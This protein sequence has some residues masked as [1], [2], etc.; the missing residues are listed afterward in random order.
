MRALLLAFIAT[1]I[2]MPASADCTGRTF[3]KTTVLNPPL[4]LPEQPKRIIALVPAFPLGVTIELGM[5]VVGSPLVGMNDVVMRDK[6]IAAGVTDLGSF[7]EPSIEKIIALKPD[8]IIGSDFLGEE[9]YQRASRIAPTAFVTAKNWKDHYRTIAEIGG[10]SDG[11][12]TLFADY[13]RRLAVLRERVPKDI[14]VS[15]VR[16]MS[17]EFQVYLDKPDTWAPFDILREAGVKRTAFETSETDEPTKRL[18]FEGLSALD[19]DI[20]LY[21][22]GDLNDAA[23]SGRHEAVIANPL[24]QMLPAVK[25]KRVYRVDQATWM[26]FNGIASAHKVLDDIETY[27]IGK[28]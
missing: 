18:D 23:I 22:I 2:S 17:N 15:V 10:R 3:D 27:I 20:L 5:P 1:T 8:L 28:P 11:L 26:E 12:E 25:A 14:K 13:D 6:V 7:L 19:G 16:I 4:C 24:W 21:M 9:A